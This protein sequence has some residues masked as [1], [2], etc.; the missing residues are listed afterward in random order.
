[1][2]EWGTGFMAEKSVKE[3]ALQDPW[4][5]KLANKRQRFHLNREVRLHILPTISSRF[6]LASSEIELLMVFGCLSRWSWVIQ[7]FFYLTSVKSS[8]SVLCSIGPKVDSHS[9]VRV[10]K[11]TLAIAELSLFVT[12]HTSLW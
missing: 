6:D 8:R 7:S 11:D 10:K 3:L 2:R 9:T 1:M 4:T 12:P 5:K